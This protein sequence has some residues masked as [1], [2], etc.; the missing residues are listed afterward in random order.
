MEHLLESWG[1]WAVLIGTYLE[2]EIVYVSAMV[3]ARF[4]HLNAWSVVFW[5]FIGVWCRDMTIF[6]LARNGSRS[7]LFNRYVNP[8][9]IVKIN[10]GYQIPQPNLQWSEY[11]QKILES[12]RN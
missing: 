11:H 3:A 6:L 10:D 9:K 8:K 2:G 4:G 12:S 5:A 1:S 7:P